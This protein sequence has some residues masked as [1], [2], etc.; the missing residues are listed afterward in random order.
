MRG[1]LAWF[2]KNPVAA[3]LMMCAL[4]VMGAFGYMNLER[5]FIPQATINGMSVSV[6]WPGASPRDVE[7]QLIVW[8]E[9][10]VDGLDGIDYIEATAREGS[11][12]VNIRTKL[13][14]DYEKMLDQVKGRVDA[15]QNLPPDAFRPQIFRWDQRPDIMY[16]A[17]YGDVDRLTL[18]RAATELR[19][20][21]TKL[22]GLQLTEQI[23]KVP[24]QV[25]IEISE[26][27]LRRYNLT[28]SQVAQAISGTS[29]NQSAG[30]VETTG[31]NLQ[32]RARNL[33]NS[34]ADFERI[35]VRQTPEG[36]VVRVKDI[37]KVID[38]FDDDKFS[39]SFRGKPAAVFQVLSPDTMNITAAG[40]AIRKFEKEINET[41]PPDLKFGI[42]FDG[43]TMFDSRMNLISSNALSG[44]ALV[45][46]ILMLFLRPAVA[47]WVTIGIAAAFAGALAIAPSIGITLNM[48]SLFAFLLV[49]GI[50]VD[51][52]IVVGESIHLHNEN[53]IIGPRGAVAGGTMVM[54]PVF[55]AVITTIM[56]FVPFMLMSGP[57]SEIFS[58]ISLVVIAVLIFS[59]VEAFFILPAHLRHLKPIH[60]EEQGKFMRFQTRI[61]ESLVTF[62]RE[63][64]RPVIAMVIKFRYVT[65]SIFMG[66][67]AMA[68]MLLQAGI[69][70]SAM[71]PEVEGDMI[72]FN[73]RFP[74]GTTFERLAQVKAQVDA[75]VAELNANYEADF[76]IDTPPIENPGMITEGRS[77]EGF[78]GLSSGDT[79]RE[80]STKMIADK[81]EEYVGPIPDAYRVNYGTT[82]G[83]N[84]GG[85]GLYYG[86][87]SSD[88]EALKTALLELKAEIETYNS[89][90]RAWDG[91]ESSARE[92]RFVMKP[93]A[94]TL[95]ITLQDVSRQVREAFYGREVQRLPRNGED[96]RVMVRYPR[97]ARESIDSLKE[98]RIRGANGV[99]VPIYSIAEVEF[100]DGV[101]RI[102]R[103]DRKQ[104]NY[105]GARVRG[106]QQEVARIKSD[107]DE[108]FFPQWELRHP[109]V[110]RIQVGDD[111]LETTFMSELKVSLIA[112]LFMMYGLLAIAF[113]SYAQ[114]L[115]I[116]VAIPFAFI[117]MI[118]GNI[119]T[120]V[121]FGMMS[122]FGFFAASGVAVNDNLV[123]IDYVNRL[124]DKG[125][126]AYQAMLDACVARFRPILLTSVTT[127]I[128]ITPILFE[129]STQAEFLKPMVVAL[130]FGVLFDF[131]LTLMLVPAMYG[132]GVDIT[133][134]FRSLWRGQKQEG[135]GSQYD[136]N[137]VLALDDMDV[138]D[139]S[140]T[141]PNP[142]TGG[143]LTAEPAE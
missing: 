140:P 29:I 103:R 40:E 120:G 76:G 105:T 5:E 70:P 86:I 28:F 113:R 136:P 18:Q 10:A 72:Q 51:D 23:S 48:I 92:I 46:I 56:M 142:Q 88:P 79:R 49:I 59:L 31:G 141:T 64:F 26:D 36:G 127:F 43:S 100:A 3:N 93:G 116:M 54:K 112:I 39:A 17:L 109:R 69:A 77:V 63:K 98:L 34:Q 82:Q 83:P 111:E 133:R 21:L 12:N 132:I 24:E 89:V 67:M 65:L 114:P 81:L 80:V 13:S 52:A 110:S 134:V 16:L 94:E 106:D 128:G 117:G 55:F 22:T 33:A 60:P 74:E 84:S 130:A 90:P 1:L 68:V 47:M 101:G 85:G 11:G 4:F 115:L 42:W 35:I 73:A 71:L 41:L 32:L 45:L 97:E 107:L 102:Q 123:L 104:V 96:V 61:A 124:R 143:G 91:L 19:L 37:A 125:V 25:T 121:P 137:V 87:T 9:E 66:L 99:E 2:V 78:L 62:A 44:M 139:V 38:G 118:F 75:G 138:A 122:L 131:F 7:E 119:V 126:G 20:E 108:N 30:T 53:G 14:V 8:I 6:S 57:I 50:V 27:E 58:Q 15:I 135:F 95:G 129:T